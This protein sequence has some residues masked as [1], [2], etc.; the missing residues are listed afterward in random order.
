[1]EKIYKGKGN[2]KDYEHSLEFLNEVFFSD[3]D[4]EDK[5]DFVT[6]LPKL[7]KEGCY[8][9]ENNLIVS[10]DGKWKGAV[11]LYCNDMNVNGHEIKCAGIGNVAVALDA[12]GKGYMKECMQM[13]MCDAVKSGADFAIL[14]GQRQR[15]AYFSFEPAGVSYKFSFNDR[16]LEHVFGLDYNSGLETVKVTE[17]ADDA[18][19]FIEEAYN[20]NSLKFIR[21][22]AKLFDILSSWRQTAYAFKR[23]EKFVGY[24]VF[25]HEND[26][27]AEVKAADKTEFKN[28][29][30]D[31]LKVSGQERITFNIPAFETDYVEC[32]SDICEG[33]HLEHCAMMS[34]LNWKK[35][36]SAAFDLQA[37][38][39]RLCDGK[40]SFIVH[41]YKKDEAFT[42][43]VKDNKVSVT[44]G[45]E[46]AIELTHREAMHLFLGLYSPKRAKLDANTAQWFPLEFSVLD[47][48]KV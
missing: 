26:Y 17:N 43:T 13:T 42:V 14:G 46:D 39:K 24:C 44:D 41:G 25:N 16:N 29:L 11:G 47:T 19:D 21:D 40:A 30:P 8:H 3:D 36:I 9:C 32:L 20:K 2:S 4:S 33:F 35:F 38:Y 10:V 45:A 18:L 7:Y 23:G 15:Y 37:A 34:V 12:R 28:M 31:I 6:L 22:R 27:V 5:R 48:D 1:M